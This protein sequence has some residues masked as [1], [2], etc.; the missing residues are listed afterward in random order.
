MLEFTF[1][2]GVNSMMFVQTVSMKSCE[3]EVIWEIIEPKLYRTRPQ[4]TYNK[5]MVVSSE[6][7]FEPHNSAEIQM[8]SYR[9]YPLAV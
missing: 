9:S 6:V 2:F 4:E 8:I 7:G 3:C 1:F 5:D